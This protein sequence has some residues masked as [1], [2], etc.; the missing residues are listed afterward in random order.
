ML[1][2]F[3]AKSMRLE[4]QRRCDA[5]RRRTN[6][7]EYV[8]MIRNLLG[9]SILVPFFCAETHAFSLQ[10]T[11]SIRENPKLR[12]AAEELKKRGDVLGDAVSEA[13]RTMDESEFMKSVRRC[14]FARDRIRSSYLCTLTV[15][16]ESLRGCIEECSQRY[17]TDTQYRD[18]QDSRRH[19][20]RSAR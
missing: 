19:R 18:I 1:S 15:D 14:R 20:T 7:P 12:A 3:T 4:I 16:A 13:I 6:E 17:R 11:T 10:L 5:P 2:S 8:P 9:L